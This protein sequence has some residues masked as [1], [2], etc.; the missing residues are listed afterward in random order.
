MGS[1]AG[2]VTRLCTVKL[3]ERRRH[4]IKIRVM[5]TIVNNEGHIKCF[6]IAGKYIAS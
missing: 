1:G 2:R 6:T 3:M 5:I 4:S